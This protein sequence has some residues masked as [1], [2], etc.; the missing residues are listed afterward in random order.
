MAQSSLSTIARELYSQVLSFCTWPERVAF[1]ALCREFGELSKT[2]FFWRDMCL[3]LNLHGAYVPQDLGSSNFRDTFFSQLW[4]YRVSGKG[5]AEKFSI[6]VCVRFKPKKD[7]GGGQRV[8]LPL[9]QRMKL[10]KATGA[11]GPDYRRLLFGG[12]TSADSFWSE[13]DDVLVQKGPTK[14][15][16]QHVT[17]NDDEVTNDEEEKT[18]DPFPENNISFSPHNE[19]DDE[20]KEDSVPFAH[21]PKTEANILG[22]DSKRV[23]MCVPGMGLR[24]FEFDCVYPAT[25]TQTTVYQQTRF[26]V[27]DFINGLNACLLCYGQTGS[28]KTFTMFGP[29]EQASTSIYVDGDSGLVPRVCRDVWRAMQEWKQM[30]C[31]LSVSYVEVFGDEINDLLHE[32]GRVGA[33]QGVAA[34]AVHEGAAAVLIRSEEDLQN[35]LLTGERAK[36]RAATAMNERSSRAHSLLLLS[37]TRS[38]DTGEVRSVMCLADLGGSEQVK[39]SGVEGERM[40]EAIQINMGLLALKNVITALV[41][42]TKHSLEH[43]PYQASK[44]TM[45]LQSA[46]GGNSKTMVITTGSTEASNAQETLAVLRFGEKCCM[47]Q[48]VAKKNINFAAELIRAIEKEIKHC[49]QQIKLKERWET[50]KVVRQDMEGQETQV[51]T[52][53]VGAEQERSVMEGL[54]KQK[55]ALLGDV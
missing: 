7:F 27:L 18:T 33:W 3:M 31:E 37:L 30:K 21:I 36:R 14:Q 5:S 20:L 19:Q 49:E 12:G 52:A 35:A 40:V 53:L 9:H 6:S 45:L 15:R 25:A 22:S 1:L 29:D 43:V 8:V 47:V 11:S 34:R 4:K 44:L 38:S 39:K 26:L 46:L 55:A 2:Q 50:V 24:E 51:V 41:R 13:A 42:K 54:L 23:L 28:G 10:I 17:I 48:N 16:V 32:G